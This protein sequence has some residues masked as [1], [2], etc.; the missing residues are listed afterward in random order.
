MLEGVGEES[1][2]I[3][4]LVRYLTLM[5]EKDEVLSQ[6]RV[7]GEISNFKRHARGHL[8]FTLKD[9]HTRIRAVMFA[10]NTRRLRFT[11]KDGDEVLIRG[12]VGVYERDGQVQLYV[13]W[14]QPRGVGDRYAAFQE[15]KEKLEQEGLFS[16]LFKK[17]LPFFPRRVG[18]ITSAHG[19][20][21]RDIITTIKRRNPAV[22][23]LLLPV[24]VQGEDSP[25]AVA[26]AIQEMNGFDVDVMIVGR[27]GGSLEELWSFNE[28]IVVR[29]I[30]DSTIPVVS[31]VGH[32]TDTSL[33]DFVADMRAATPTAAAELVTPRLDDQVS[34]LSV[35]KNSLLRAQQRQIDGMKER[36]AYAVS[37]PLFRRPRTRLDQEQ[38]RLD[39]VTADL[40]RGIRFRLSRQQ[41]E[42]DHHRTRIQAQ[43][44]QARLASISDRLNRLNHGC[45]REIHRRIKE[46]KDQWHRRVE[47]L[48]AL[49]PLKV[50]SRGYSLVYRQNE[51]ELVRSVRQIQPGDL[52][53]VRVSDGK[54]KAQV[55]G[56]EEVPDGKSR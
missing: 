41:H 42:L 48:D 19:A 26:K 22:N 35:L 52:I 17:P 15:L 25:G 2:T 33:A 53:K 29:S 37:R 32:E 24:P 28:E 30:Y 56:W 18:V 4:D 9:E 55:W 38:Q 51:T 45:K 12:R 13:T 1:F 40:I 8:Y 3:T 44:P 46:Q 16:P 11:P 54:L 49:S 43:S 10:G 27:G 50:M 21:V 5:V 20:A 23:I 34:R 47:R 31:A 36:L 6:L 7:Q 14:M 39:Y